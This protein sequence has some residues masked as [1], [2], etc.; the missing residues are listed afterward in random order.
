ML[1]G[2]QEMSAWQLIVT[3]SFSRNIIC[4]CFPIYQP[5]KIL[6]PCTESFCLGCEC[7]LQNLFTIKSASEFPP[8]N[9]LI[10][11][12]NHACEKQTPEC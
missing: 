10:F 1:A 5:T 3:E 8:F 12:F 7:L 6:L 11:K 2:R 9:F 4:I